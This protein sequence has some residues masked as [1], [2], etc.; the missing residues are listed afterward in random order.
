MSR[1]SSKIIVAAASAF[2]LI[3]LSLGSAASVSAQGVCAR[4][5]QVRWGETLFSIAR[6]Y[7]LTVAQIQ[8]LNG[9]APYH[10]RIYAG[11]SL[12]VQARAATPTPAPTVPNLTYM[13]QPG[14]TI[15]SIAR[16]FGLDW[17]QLA[18]ANNLYNPN[19]IYSGQILIIPQYATQ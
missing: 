3:S 17:R 18:A 4:A 19:A 7:G 10:T 6:S 9:M 8:R 12:C 14:D 13:V 15:Y 1:F 5:H 16:K 2:I 11:Q